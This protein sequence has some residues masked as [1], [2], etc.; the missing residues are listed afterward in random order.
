[1][2]P[3]IFNPRIF[4]GSPFRATLAFKNANGTAKDLTGATGKFQIRKT[5]N[6]EEVLAEGYLTITSALSG[7]GYI[8][9]TSA[10]TEAIPTFGKTYLDISEYP[11]DFELQYSPADP[12]RWFHGVA[13]VS[14]GVTR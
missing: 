8:S 12:E 11:F 4:K 9:L 14:P 5:A 6:S 1:M 2:I 3:G 7:T 10:Q 13:Q